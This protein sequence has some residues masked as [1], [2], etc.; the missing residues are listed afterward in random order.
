MNPTNQEEITK[1]EKEV[2]KR[3]DKALNVLAWVIG[4][5]FCAYL[6]F[7]LYMGLGL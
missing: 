7:K 6:L 5:L 4:I 2:K 3:K 1:T